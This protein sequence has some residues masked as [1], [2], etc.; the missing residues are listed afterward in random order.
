MSRLARRLL[1]WVMLMVMGSMTLR[2]PTDLRKYFYIWAT[3]IWVWRSRALQ[4][5]GMLLKIERGSAWERP[6]T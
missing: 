6:G 4:S 5:T 2:L 3:G 1:R